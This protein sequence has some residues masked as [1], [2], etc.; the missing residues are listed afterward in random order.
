[1]SED[2]RILAIDPAL[3]CTG[4]A[5]VIGTIQKPVLLSAGRI[6]LKIKDKDKDNKDLLA[7][8]CIGLYNDVADLVQEFDPDLAVVELPQTFSIGFGSKRSA[9]TLPGYGMAVAAAL[10]GLRTGLR[11]T[12]NG[13]K[14][15][16]VLTPSASEW[17][18]GFPKT[19]GD[20]DK[21]ARVH[22]AAYL[23]GTIPRHFGC[24][25]DAGNVADAALLGFWAMGQEVKG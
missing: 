2:R 20:P 14:L 6:R 17:T 7:Q 8:R 11:V 4:F 5:V 9:A 15:R 22:H 18:K 19:K 23:F 10:F 25:S 3:G 13:A 24:K 21:V 16:A 1:M 12:P